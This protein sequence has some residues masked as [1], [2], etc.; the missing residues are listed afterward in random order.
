ML[1]PLPRTPFLK[2]PP[3]WELFAYFCVIEFYELKVD[4]LMI[5]CFYEIVA[6]AATASC[7]RLEEPTLNDLG[8]FTMAYCVA[9]LFYPL[10]YVIRILS[11]S[12]WVAD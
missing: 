5:A 1:K 10:C 11:I 6:A 8:L 2:R 12:L 3:V 4:L 7:S 9:K